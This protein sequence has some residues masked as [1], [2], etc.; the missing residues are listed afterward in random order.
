MPLSAPSARKKLHTRNIELNG[1]LREDGLFD[2][3]AHMTDIK[4][5]SIDNKWRDGSAPGEALHEMWVR[6]TIDGNFKIIDVEATTDN[7]PFEMCPNITE[8]YKDLIG[9][10]IGAG[11]RRTVNEKVKG[12]KGCTHI[13]ELMGPLATVSFQTMMG[14]IQKKNNRE[15]KKKHFKPMVLNSCHAWADDSEV[16]KTFFPEYYAG[17]KDA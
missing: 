7:S 2:I 10:N 5:Y 16:V 13:S 9:I 11:W 14:N 17:E 6:L 15:D 8:A 12:K 4:T 1:Y 3:E